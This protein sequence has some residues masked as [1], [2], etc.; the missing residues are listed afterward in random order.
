MNFNKEHPLCNAKV[1]LPL[2][3][4][5]FH[6]L[7]KCLSQ[8]VFIQNTVKL[9]GHDIFTQNLAFCH[10]ANLGPVDFATANS[11]GL[12][13]LDNSISQEKSLDERIRP[14]FSTAASYLFFDGTSLPCA[15]KIQGHSYVLPHCHADTVRKM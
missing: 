14:Y 15:K 3:K 2:C 10:E 8:M 5:E 1:Y 9:Y 13:N 7:F 12:Q 4:A 11:K 6:L